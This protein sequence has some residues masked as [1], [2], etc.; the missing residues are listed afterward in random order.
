MNVHGFLGEKSKEINQIRII[1]T[2]RERTNNNK[3]NYLN[4]NNNTVNVGVL[5]HHVT[6]AYKYCQGSKVMVKRWGRKVRSGDMK[7]GR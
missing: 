1:I 5:L 7:S 3:N 6:R 4:N 2:R